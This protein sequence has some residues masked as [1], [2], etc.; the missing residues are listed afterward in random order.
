VEVGDEEEA[1]VRVL[2]L[3]PVVE[4]AHIVA[5]VEATGGAHTAEDAGALWDGVG[6]SHWQSSARVND[7]WEMQ[8]VGK[9]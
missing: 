8:A 2:K 6:F 9:F 1:V 5:E 7:S 4:G 3:D